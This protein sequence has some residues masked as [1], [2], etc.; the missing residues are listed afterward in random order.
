MAT[1]DQTKTTATPA[2]APAATAAPTASMLS[3][4]FDEGRIGVD[5]RALTQKGLTSLMEKIIADNATSE[6]I[7]SK[8]IDGMLADIDLKIAAQI[9]AVLHQADFQKL[10]ATWRGLDYLVRNT[11]FQ[12]NIKIDVLA[13]TKDELRDDLEDAPSILE[14]GLYKTIYTGE[15][16][17][18]GGQPY[19]A[20]IGG[21]E[22]DCSSR[23]VNLLRE[24]G[25]VASMSFAPF[26]AGTSPAFFNLDDWRGLSNLKDFGW[27]F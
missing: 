26:I 25:A 1:T 15:Y 8:L 9:D 7:S 3:Q 18:F 14:S 16:G 6:K 23:D 2:A 5:Q 27:S 11:N 21:Y 22:F 24:I 17:Q 19:G 10:E 20:I 13:A 4:L 12:E